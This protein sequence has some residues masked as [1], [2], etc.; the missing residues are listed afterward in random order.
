M[1]TIEKHFHWGRYF[2]YQRSVF[3]ELRPNDPRGLQPTGVDQQESLSFAVLG[4]CRVRAI[5]AMVLIVTKIGI[6]RC[7]EFVLQTTN[8]ATWQKNRPKSR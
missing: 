3:L 7:D 5:L 6:E 2:C 1:L 8:A 4:L